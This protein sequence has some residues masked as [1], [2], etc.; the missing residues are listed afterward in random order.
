M[1]RWESVAVLFVV[2]SC[3]GTASGWADL[4]AHPAS[5]LAFG[6]DG[7]GR[8]GLFWGT[9]GTVFT[10][11]TT[12]TDLVACDANTHSNGDI[13]PV[14][15][16]TR[17][18]ELA[19][20]SQTTFHN[21][22]P[23]GAPA[24]T[25]W[26]HALDVNHQQMH[27]IALYRAWQGGLRFMMADA[28]DNE[29]LDMLWL[30]G[31]AV[32]AGHVPT[33]AAG[34]AA[35]SARRQL[36]W[37]HTLAAIN[38]TWMTI[39]KSP[40]EARAALAANKLAVVLGVEMDNLTPSEILALARD[41]D[42]RHVI[43]VHLADNP[44]IGASASYGDIF[45]TNGA[46]LNGS[47]QAVESD[48]L[49]LFRFGVPQRLVPGPLNAVVPAP[50]R[51]QEACALGYVPCP[52]V[53]GGLPLEQGLRNK[54]GLQANNGIQSMMA[55]GLLIDVAHMSFHS[56]EETLAL[57]ERFHYPVLDSHTGLRADG[58]PG[59]S[60]R[61]L[62]ESQARRIAALGGV[63][64]LGTG[65]NVPARVLYDGADAPL[66]SFTDGGASFTVALRSTSTDDPGDLIV[67]SLVVSMESNGYNGPSG[68]IHASA[69]VPLRSGA[70]LTL[71]FA[72]GGLFQVRNSNVET[73][74]L[75]AG[76]RLGDIRGFG[77][78]TDLAN[79][80]GGW[81]LVSVRA[82]YVV[83]GG[84]QGTLMQH[85][86]HTYGTFPQNILIDS[87]NPRWLEVFRGTYA[88]HTVGA[89]TLT[90]LLGA[91]GVPGQ[92][93]NLFGNVALA[94]G[95]SFHQQLNP[96]DAAWPGGSRQ[97]VSLPVPQGTSIDDVTAISV[98]AYDR[99]AAIGGDGTDLVRFALEL[100]AADGVHDELASRAGETYT[101]LGRDVP[102]LP[103]YV[104]ARDPAPAGSG[105]PNPPVNFVR[106]TVRPADNIEAGH[107]LRAI[108]RSA[109]GELASGEMTEGGQWFANNSY[110]RILAL[111][112]GTKL[113]DLC[114][115]DL[116]P[117]GWFT[118]G[119]AIGE[120][121]LEALGDPVADWSRLYNRLA[122]I[123]P[124]AGV[125][126]DMN[127]LAPQLPFSTN[128]VSFPLTVASSRMA[129]ATAISGNS[130]LASRSFTIEGDG[131]AHYGMLPDFLAA[132][133]G[134]PGG[135]DTVNGLF[136]SAE[137]A[138]AMWERAAAAAHSVPASP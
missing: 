40:A 123:A 22:L 96:S 113:R 92:D 93:E 71:P 69:S 10:L 17:Q 63:V 48:P 66:V 99:P 83:A 5:H 104:R 42:V 34:F 39:V 125:G 14:G 78:S 135:T 51:W 13:N 110:A 116:K 122:A 102:E 112:A 77:I 4:H 2:A 88:G 109:T 119:V 91:R 1:G 8:Q 131:L 23:S 133:E 15:T 84:S 126:T 105:D 50:V 64:G 130:R 59:W 117:D 85:G 87:T 26:P 101:P 132:L 35:T 55:A 82:D 52:G 97:V 16:T 89:L 18:S 27:V 38:P 44:N 68:G 81:R 28:T 98:S 121:K 90:L 9:P 129:G 46:W 137:A 79:A 74:S 25:G 11:D 33:P 49:L 37:L 54:H 72:S 138:I 115:L 20:V 111:P 118:R 114:W 127:G 19:A 134:V 86:R 124:G 60:E 12:A 108:V 95:R 103:L 24:C 36:S 53:A 30:Q 61:D 31:T 41:A 58:A 21:H 106:V 45:N 100:T 29:T 65:G 67:T 62:L 73:V 136:N 94:D 75:P 6:Y 47:F 76:T 3:G 56:T 7:A 107:A 128:A 80:S 70:T 32:V 120:L 43:P 57:A